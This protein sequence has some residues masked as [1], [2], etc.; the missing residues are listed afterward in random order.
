MGD[1]G[2]DGNRAKRMQGP[3]KKK[4]VILFEHERKYINIVVKFEERIYYYYKFSL[5]K[6]ETLNAKETKEDPTEELIKLR[7][8][9]ENS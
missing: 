1:R 4:L 7:V 8:R 9:L 6:E 2:I 5:R 3:S